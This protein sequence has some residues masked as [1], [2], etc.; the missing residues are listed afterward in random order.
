MPHQINQEIL[1]HFFLRKKKQETH[2]TAIEVEQHQ[3]ER[4][5][6][7]DWNWRVR[8]NR[9]LFMKLEMKVPPIFW[10]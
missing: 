7:E 3:S 6:N 8:P 9:E 1:Q 4:H 10:F 5:L 2:N